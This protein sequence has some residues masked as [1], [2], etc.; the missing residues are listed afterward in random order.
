MRSIAST[1]HLVK[2]DSDKFSYR[3]VYRDLESS[4]SKQQLKEFLDNLKGEGNYASFME[5]LNNEE[6]LPF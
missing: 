6:L 3:E 4:L 5:V 2:D 1:L